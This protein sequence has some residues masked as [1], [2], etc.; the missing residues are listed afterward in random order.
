MRRF[1]A[2]PPG[3][4]TSRAESRGL[5]RPLWQ[6]PCRLRIQRRIARWPAARGPG[7]QWRGQDDHDPRDRRITSGRVGKGQRRRPRYERLADPP[8]DARG[9]CLRA[10]RCALL[11]EPDRRRESP[12]RPPPQRP[13]RLH[14]E[15]ALGACPPTRPLHHQPSPPPPPPPPPPLHPSSP[16]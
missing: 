6:E 13:P 7:P 15:A 3:Q 4:D 9:N 2:E 10:L 16:P 11:P 1:S 14:E 8:Q 12:D 5:G